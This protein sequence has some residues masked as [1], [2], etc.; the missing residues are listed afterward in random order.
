[1]VT[2]TSAFLARRVDISVSI[3]VRAQ[4]DPRVYE[5][6]L[7]I[8]VNFAFIKNIKKKKEASI[9][10]PSMRDDEQPAEP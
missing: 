6:N 4:E 3:G 10:D 2:R 5:R 9:E 8:A 1:M 7:L